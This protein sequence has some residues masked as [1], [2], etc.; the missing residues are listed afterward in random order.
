MVQAV[1]RGEPAEALNPHRR[2]LVPPPEIVAAPAGSAIRTFA[3]IVAGMGIKA[4]KSSTT[5]SE[6]RTVPTKVSVQTFV[7]GL[8]DERRRREAT[9]LISM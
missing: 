9:T 1:E 2:E 6:A 3:A 4:R 8:D 7:N 5:R